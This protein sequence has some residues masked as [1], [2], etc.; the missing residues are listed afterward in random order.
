MKAEKTIHHSNQ[1]LENIRKE[2]IDLKKQ[3]IQFNSSLK[4]II[5]V[6]LKMLDDE[7]DVTQTDE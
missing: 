6:H 3:K 2:I 5:E 4:S 1:E 7:G